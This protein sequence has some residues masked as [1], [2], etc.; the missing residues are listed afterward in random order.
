MLSM[1]SHQ[2]S[3]EHR[4]TWPAP[5][6]PKTLPWDVETP[7]PWAAADG[8]I[9]PSCPTQVPLSDPTPGNPEWVR[10]EGSTG[11]ICSNLP[12][13]A[14]LCQSTGMCPDTSG[15][16]PVRETPQPLCTICSSAWALHRTEIL[17][18]VQV[19]LPG[20]QFLPFALYCWAPPSRA[21]SIHPLFRD[22]YPLIKSP[23][24]HLFFLPV[25]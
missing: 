10:Q 24:R 15:I 12:A 6:L 1:E 18:H 8:S 23:L 9:N 21:W 7:A 3:R 17:P 4:G 13:Q 25:P 22:L 5:G 2:E 16:S 20:H 19:E 11:L 14:G